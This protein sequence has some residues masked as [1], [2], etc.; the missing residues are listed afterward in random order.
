MHIPALLD[1]ITTGWLSQALGY[2]VKNLEIQAIGTGEGFTGQV[3]R[4]SLDYGGEGTLPT[5]MI[6]KLPTADPEQIWIGTAMGVWEKEHQ[7]YK[8]AASEIA[9]RVPECFLNLG[10]I[11]KTRY[12]LLLEDLGELS[13][14]DQITGATPEQARICINALGELHGKW[15]LD[16]RLSKWEWIGDPYRPAFDMMGELFESSWA[17]ATDR[18]AHR[19]PPRA[20][21]WTE[22]FH[23]Q[24]TSWMRDRYCKLPSTFTHGDY[25]LDNLLFDQDDVAIIDWQSVLPNPGTTDLFFFLLTSLS[26]DMRREIEMELFDLYLE[27]LGNTGRQSAGFNSDTLWSLYREAL[28]FYSATT[29]AG[30]VHM[31]PRNERGLRLIDTLVER[32]MAAVDDHNAGEPHGL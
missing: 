1:E 31:D 12:I 18:Y 2:E 32:C 8:N 23:P 16:P 13:T 25:R 21:A 11:E 19:V 7:F 3:A 17:M 29:T 24:A 15:Y 30:V 27:A 22:A 26:V 14:I 9:Q 28:L 6:V 20:F 10:D 4:I 5:S